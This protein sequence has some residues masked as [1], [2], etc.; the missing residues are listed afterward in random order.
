[1]D[2]GTGA[3]TTMSDSILVAG[4][5]EGQNLREKRGKP[6]FKSGANAVIAGNRMSSVIMN[7]NEKLKILSNG[8]E[9][10]M[11]HIGYLTKIYTPMTSIADFTC[12]AHGIYT[13][14]KKVKK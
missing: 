9:K 14:M 13:K 3:E 8:Y 4:E 10:L 7:M 2:P 1:M 12:Q 5:G 6:T 11:N